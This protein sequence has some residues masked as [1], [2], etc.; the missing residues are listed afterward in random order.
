MDL[1]D[2]A[3][4]ADQK[5][6]DFLIYCGYNINEKKTIFGIAPMHSA[7]MKLKEDKNNPRLLEIVEHMI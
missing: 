5:S 7:I 3:A 2:A 4:T 1:K 6:L